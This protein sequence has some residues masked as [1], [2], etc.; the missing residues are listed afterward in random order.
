MGSYLVALQFAHRVNAVVVAV[1]VLGLATWSLKVH[2]PAPVGTWASWAAVLVLV[3]IALGFITVLTSLAVL[4]DSLHTLV[5]A[6][7]L[8]TLVHVTSLGWSAR[9][10]VSREPA[11]AEATA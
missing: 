9:T 6:G 8:T 1:A 11:A 3:Q 4:P 7:V 2:A 5:A 10:P